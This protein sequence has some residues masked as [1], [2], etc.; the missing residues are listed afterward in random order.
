[1]G[2]QACR[3]FEEGKEVGPQLRAETLIQIGPVNILTQPE[4]EEMSESAIRRSG[5]A[6]IPAAVMIFLIP[7]LSEGI[8]ER[9]WAPF[10]GLMF[11]LLI[12]ALL[13]MR[14]AQAGRDGAL[15]RAG[16][17]IAVIGLA[18][19]AIQS[20]ISTV[21]VTVLGV[22]L[23][24]YPG[25]LQFFQLDI[26][27]TIGDFGSQLGILLFAIVAIRAKVLPRWGA[28][29]LLGLPLMTVI[30][31]ATGGSVPGGPPPDGA[32]LLPLPLPSLGVLL[33]A[34]GLL[35]L[36]YTLWSGRV[37]GRGS[38]QLSEVG[39]QGE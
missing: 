21:L 2:L 9:A 5:M 18:I 37:T 3:L 17:V 12:A 30:A 36:G 23:K 29:L 22:P 15:G 34:T 39:V 26:F 16:L 31:L 28:A 24:E 4:G 14:S 1:L 32:P 10:E 11:L 27:S 6:A 35:W 33:T 8:P 19:M 25:W 38:A 20:A 7:L 13:G